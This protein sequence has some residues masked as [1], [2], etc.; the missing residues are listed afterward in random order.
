VLLDGQV[1]Q[2]FFDKQADNTVGVEDEV[3]TVCVFVAD[4][5]VKKRDLLVLVWEHVY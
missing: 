4:D 2:A 5:A 1:V 3:G